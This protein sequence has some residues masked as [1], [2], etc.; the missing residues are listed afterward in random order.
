MFFRAVVLFGTSSAAVGAAAAP[1]NPYA[2]LIGLLP[3]LVSVIMVVMVRALIDM[4][5]QK[6]QRWNYNILV[7]IFCSIFAAVVVH[8]YALS[9]VTAMLLGIGVGSTG[10][11]LIKFGKPVLLSFMKKAVDTLE[12]PPEK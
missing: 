5:I 9:M 7:M 2:W 6:K 1:T 10:V 3:M 12:D 8:E 11:G 4:Q